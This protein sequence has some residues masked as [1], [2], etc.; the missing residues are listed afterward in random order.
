[1]K[2]QLLNRELWLKAKGLKDPFN[3]ESIRAEADSLLLSSENEAFIEFPYYESIK[4]ETDIPG[5]RFIFAGRGAGKTAL[6]LRLQKSFD[7]DL[8]TGAGSVLAVSYNN[9]DRV[10]ENA[11]HDPKQVIPRHHVVEIIGLIIKRLFESVVESRKEI[12]D[13]ILQTE[14]T[15]ELFKW[16]LREFKALHSWDINYLLGEVEGVE[17]YF[18]PKRLLD[19]AKGTLDITSLALPPGAQQAVKL[20]SNLLNFEDVETIDAGSVS[21]VELLEELVHLCSLLGFKAIYI[22]VDDV[23][24]PQYYGDQKDYSPAFDLIHS[25]ASAPKIIGIPKLIFKFFLPIEIRPQCL[26][27]LRLDKFS[28]QVITWA[29]K[30]LE[31]VFDSRVRAAYQKSTISPD[32]FDPSKTSE[33]IIKEICA[34]DLSKI[35]G[36][37]LDFAK[38]KGSPRA[39]LYVGNEMLVEHFRLNRGLDDKIIRATWERARQRAEEVFQ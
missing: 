30:D 8:K 10:L 34:D 3:P 19:I 37:M 9:F 18:S 1:M 31:E 13:E 29:Y 4:G 5:P 14:R 24:E 2:E 22:L 39:L 35:R 6:R 7:D 15:R 36:W 23:D 33:D 12:S 28:E 21:V 26:Q 11:K 27:S 32:T 25:L 17:Y 20:F 38:E 16:Y